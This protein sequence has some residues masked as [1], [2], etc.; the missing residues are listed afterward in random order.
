MRGRPVSARLSRRGNPRT[1]RRRLSPTRCAC[2]RRAGGRVPAVRLARHAQ[3]P[4]RHR[5]SRTRSTLVRSVHQPAAG[6]WCSH[7]RRGR[8][9]TR[10]SCRCLRAA[11]RP[12]TPS[13]RVPSLDHFVT[14]WMSTV[15]VSAGSWRSSSQV[16]RAATVP[17]SS[18]TVKSH[19][20]GGVN[21]VGPAASTGKSSTR[22]WPGGISPAPSCRPRPW[23]PRL[24]M[25]ICFL[26]PLALDGRLLVRP[27]RS[28][29]TARGWRPWLRAER[30]S[31]GLRRLR[32]ERRAGRVRGLRTC[33]R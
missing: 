14:L 24:T 6:S 4:T 20:S 17:V 29:A 31:V 26:S 22:Y 3:A 2:G 8:S 16:H 12:E 21:G 7:R 15:G 10:H 5:R 32:Y 33:R 9:R 25:P 18:T 19:S 11:C 13:H 23:N 30:P 28:G 1:P 27:A